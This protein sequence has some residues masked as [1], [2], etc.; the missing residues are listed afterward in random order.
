MNRVGPIGSV[1][2][3][4]GRSPASWSTQLQRLC[5]A[6]HSKISISY[7][8]CTVGVGVGSRLIVI[9]LFSSLSTLNSQKCSV[10]LIYHSLQVHEVSFCITYFDRFT[11]GISTVG[12]FIHFKFKNT[13]K[14]QALL[15]Q[16]FVWRTEPFLWHIAKAATAK[17]AKAECAIVLRID[18]ARDKVVYE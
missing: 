10:S 12:L 3:P 16:C 14:I 7:A 5:L 13:L 9:V 18:F 2:V 4:S 15:S 1:Y 11:K 6:P 17:P 8:L